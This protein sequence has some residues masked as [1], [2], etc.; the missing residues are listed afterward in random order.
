MVSLILSLVYVVAVFYKIA[1]VPALFVD[2]ANYAS[3][4]ISF[5]NFG[6]DIHGLHNPI[7]FSSV[8]GQGQSV[9]YSFI[10]RPVIKMFGF[11]FFNFRF[12]MAF[13]SVVLIFII[14]GY[15]LHVSK[16]Y[17]A[18]FLMMLAFITSPWWFTMARW[19]LDANIAP[20]FVGFSLMA[21]LFSFEKSKKWKQIL[22]LF[23]S[24]LLMGLATYGYIATWLYLPVF[25]FVLAVFLYKSNLLN[26][27]MIV[28]YLIS[29]LVMVLPLIYF[30]FSIFIKHISKPVKFLWMDVPPLPQSR[31][32][33]LID[34]SGNVVNTMLHNFISGCQM[35]WSGTD[36]LSRNSTAPFGMV[37][38]W[39]LVV[40]VII[41]LLSSKKLLPNKLMVLKNICVI[42]L[43]TFVP[44]ALITVP[45]FTHW[46]LIHVPLIVLS[47]IGMYVVASHLPRYIWIIL[48]LVISVLPMSVFVHQYFQVSSAYRTGN[49]RQFS[50]KNTKNINQFMEKRKKS[51]LFTN[52]VSRNFVYFR[53]YQKPVD[54]EQYLA[55]QEKKAEFSSSMG[56]KKKY[57]YL[58][59]ITE[60]KKEYRAAHDYI[61]TISKKDKIND[62]KL[63]HSHLK[64]IKTFRDGKIVY[65]LDKITN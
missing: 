22:G 19:V 30:A 59:N 1:T 3:E 57:G 43:I 8:W 25:L 27:K 36:S 37:F 35:Y 31:T 47:G 7:Y 54:H 21:L 20:L 12:P 5:T 46:N 63:T 4:V 50:M 40:F 16:N 62:E 60:I 56:P 29:I 64:T 17:L 32:S 15:V 33:S 34:F 45:N 55:T 44:V 23:A 6:T 48:F 49:V 13:L 61:L 53:V 38:P 42:A 10:V 14:C 52:P 24:A 28:V 26:I 65:K 51:L 9:L 41:G 2:E 18:T 58:R 11:N 39:V